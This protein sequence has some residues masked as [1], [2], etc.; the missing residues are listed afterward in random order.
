MIMI[1]VKKFHYKRISVIILT[2]LF[3]FCLCSLVVTKLVYDHIFTRY[4]VSP[5]IPAP[6]QSTVDTRRICQFASGDAMLT[7]YYYAA[8]SPIKQ[9]PWWFLFRAFTPAEMT[10]CGRFGS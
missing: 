3:S 9:T 2:I 4:E 5:E 6:L 8:P 10:T 1:S 7:G